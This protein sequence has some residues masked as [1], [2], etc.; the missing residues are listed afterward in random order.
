MVSI[1]QISKIPV[2][3]LRIYMTFDGE[4]SPYVS[5]ITKQITMVATL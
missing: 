4:S 2:D 5:E 3:I 1:D